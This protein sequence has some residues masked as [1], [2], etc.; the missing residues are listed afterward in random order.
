MSENIT[1]PAHA[2]VRAKNDCAEIVQNRAV[3]PPPNTRPLD[4]RMGQLM[5]GGK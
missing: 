3:S 4:A 1:R 2:S 5:G